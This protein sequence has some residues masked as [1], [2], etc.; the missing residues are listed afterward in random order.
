MKPKRI[1]SIFLV[2]CMIAPMLFTVP[3][4]A[5]ADW[6]YRVKVVVSDKKDAGC[7][8]KNAIKVTLTFDGSDET[9]YLQGKPSRGDTTQAVIKSSRAP[10]TLDRVELENTTKD[11]LWMYRIYIE[12]QRDGVRAYA[13]LLDNYPGNKDD[14]K[15]GMPIDVDDGGP[16]RYAVKFN[17]S[18]TIQYPDDFYTQLSGEEY[19]SSSGE[20]GTVSREWSGKLADD[21]CYV[22]D[23]N[24]MYNCMEMSDPPEFKISASGIKGDGS[25][26]SDKDL[27]QNGYTPTERGFKADKAALVSYMNKNNINAVTI[28]TT[29]TFSDKSTKTNKY[30]NSEAKY[31]F[32][33]DTFSISS[34]NL[35]SNYFTAGIDNYFYNNSGNRKITATCTIKTEGNCRMFNSWVLAN[36][37]IKFDNAYLKAGDNIKITAI[38][39]QTGKA[40]KGAKLSGAAF[41]LEFPYA[42]NLD[43]E[44]AGTALV[45]ENAKLNYSFLNFV[46]HDYKLWDEVHHRHGFANQDN[47]EGYLVST[48]KIDSKNPTVVL[49]AASGTDLNKWNKTV[50]LTSTPS[51]DI[52][53]YLTRGNMRTQGYYTMY[54][55]DGINT[56]NIY[57][58]NYTEKD[59]GTAATIQKAPA[60]KNFTQNVTLALRDK[61]EGV[62][63]LVLTGQDF[64]GNPLSV[65]HEGIK[66]DNK[67]PVV[68]I[69]EKQ[70][71]KADGKKG[72]IYNV[73][74]SDASGTGRLYYMFTKKSPADAPQYDGSNNPATSGSMDTTLDRWAFI[75]QKDTENGK[76]AAAYLDVEKG[77]SFVG[78]IMYFAVDEA[79]N[80]TE[81][82]SKEININNED[83]A[84]SI[85]P[86]NPDYPRSGY[87]ITIDTNSNNTVEYRWKYYVKENADSDRMT[88]KF[89]TDYYNKYTGEI[90][91][92][93]DDKTKNL[94]GTYI[95][96][97]KVTPPSGTNIKYY[98]REYMFDN[99]G[100]TINITTP[101]AEAKSNQTITV[102]ATDASDV[103]SA[104]AKLTAPNGSDIAGN[105][106]FPVNVTDGILSQNININNAASGAYALKVT[107]TDRNGLSNTE[108][109]KPFFIRNTAP[110]GTV[111]VSSSL[112]YNGRSLISNK[113]YKLDFDITDSFMNAASIGGQSLYYRVSAAAGEYGEWIKAGAM[114]SGGNE[115]K[116]KLTADALPIEFVD[117]ENI[118]FVQTAVSS[119]SADK[120]KIDLNTV[121]TDE[122]VF[123]YDNTPPSS[124]LVIDDAHTSES[125]KGKLYVADNLDND[126]KASCNSSAVTIGDFTNSAFDVTV[127]ENTDTSITVKDTAGN[128]TSVKLVIKGIDTTPPTAE[129]SV[130]DKYTGVRKDAAATVKINDVYGGTV[131]IGE[132]EQPG[133]RFAFIPADKYDGSGKIPE[134]FFRDNLDNY[135]VYKV[136]ES[137]SEQAQWDGESNM[138][139]N[140]DI[141][142]I[143]GEWFVGVR[144]ADSLG[145]MTDIIFD[146]TISAQDAELSAELSVK[147][148]KTEARTIGRVKYNVPVY[149]LPQ[150]KIVDINSDAVKNNTLNLELNGLSDKEK[151]E[152][153]NLELA[154][155]Y[156]M[157]Y[158]DSYSFAASANGDYELYTVDDI[159]RTKHMT[160][161][162]S[163]VEFGAASGI[164]ATVYKKEWSDASQ[165]LVYNPVGENEMV[166]AVSREYETAVVIEPT[167]ASDTL[168][169]PIEELDGEHT[170]GLSFDANR[171]EAVYKDNA[172]VPSVAPDGTG[173]S[174]YG[175]KKIQGYK[176]LVYGVSQI[177][178]EDKY[179]PANVT[180]RAV[181]VKA[182]NKDADTSNPDEVSEKTIVI[183]GI[184]NTAPAV[185]WSSN[186]EVYTYED[187]TQDGYTYKDWVTHPTPGN[188]EFTLT[189]QDKESGITEI[190]VLTYMDEN[191]N[192]EVVKVPLADET[193]KEDGYWSWD[194]SGHR[195][196]IDYD[197]DEETGS[198]VPIY[199]TIPVKAEYYGDS[200]MYGVKT[201]KL[202]FT[203]AYRLDRAGAFV[204]SLGGEGYAFI[205][206]N[207]SGISTYDVIYKMPIT[208]GE[209]YN[210]KYYY[211]NSEGNWE[212]ITDI[213]NTYYKN[214][215]A[216]IEKAGRADERG[217]YVT[218][219]SGADGE[220]LAEKPLNNYQNSFTF[221]LKDK[222]G[223]TKSV[224]VLLENFD[225]EPGELSYALSTTSKTNKPV[226]VTIEVSDAKSGVGTVK[227]TG[228]GGE[229]ALTKLEDGKYKGE[230]SKNG[231][232]SAAL[233]DKAGNKT[234]KSFNISNI[235]TALP[236]A[237]V[238]YSTKELTSRPVTATLSFSK[239]NVRITT[240]EPVAPLTEADYSVNYTTSVITFT[241][242]GT[243]GV[244]FEDDYGNSNAD[245]PL[246]V[247]VGNIDKT[248]PRLEPVIDNTTEPSVAAVTF[249]KVEDLA[250]ELSKQRKESE[251][252]VTYGGI[253][254]AVAD[255]KGS[256]NSFVFYQNGNYTFKVHDKE[257]MSSYLSITI[258]GIDLKAPVIKSVSWSYDYDEYDG[259][260]WIARNF[261]ETITPKEGSAG[262]VVASD[263]YN[264]TNKDVTVTVTTDD[265]T[266]LVGSSDDY[267]KVKEKNYDQNGLFIFNP[268]KRNN[269]TASY[270]VDIEVIDKAAPTIDLLG[271]SEMVFY[272][273]PEM[274]TDYDRSMLEYVNGGKYKAY[275]AYDIF[276]GVKTDLTESVKVVDWGGFNPNNLNSNK[277]DS[278]S[279]YTITYQ[280]SDKAHNITEAKRTIRLIGMYDTVALVNGKL[281]DFAGR[282]E[283]YGDS[284]KISLKNFAGTAYAR[285]QKGV[286]T[287]GQ[288]KKD[289]TLVSRNSDGDFE[290]T[291]LSEGWYTFYVQT[292]KRD[293]FTLCVYLCN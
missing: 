256:K 158:S 229:T 110:T 284:V 34:V 25:A 15:S 95:L 64:A 138:V 169:L 84:C 239:P 90:D 224:P 73:K 39:P 93:K 234:V 17:P 260:D 264:V 7:G 82:N 11:S 102:Y 125:I 47:F 220:A 120:N 145:N 251:I 217:L 180:E 85:T 68:E 214:A 87:N 151:V 274:N 272:E 106:E 206:R 119:D 109:S 28:T 202:T 99:E 63:K 52:Y 129:M 58:F 253:T 66:L 81:V 184:D 282:S 72:N 62:Y 53:S 175:E 49:S 230:I 43:S 191:G 130:T 247:A 115:L 137:R 163:G 276:G 233:Y 273:N 160:V 108:L 26:A 249:N 20:S 228:G 9:G 257:G 3:V 97:C 152:A 117:G 176:K 221:K 37:T 77:Q 243:V 293:Y 78:R 126:L 154:K 187:V 212:E 41:S 134:G 103:V 177:M 89:I 57:K 131:K 150:D 92:L 116:A 265:D 159:G 133:I 51:E 281:P 183:G 54:L 29:L 242:S 201:L 144:A 167:D 156:A 23:S 267:G 148:M 128:E 40:A 278:G 194:G 268:E 31:T 178:E 44:N 240:I 259:T 94:N 164:K 207:E 139:Y 250:S 288:M 162:V 199:G 1:L 83:T 269:L 266:R 55:T 173:G 157:S 56:P 5:A 261:S 98:T 61:V 198:S 136:S 59:T 186:P 285:Y 286:K 291:G 80:K 18:R 19:L 174:D 124:T 232:Y 123:Y 188:V 244:C 262:Y 118:L 210:L 127:S 36:S 245:N 197:Y 223:Y 182:F 27:Q 113:E 149:T 122:I 105:D 153:V 35:S 100:P 8:K 235:N 65:V 238:S 48:H 75:E 219:C 166:C 280:V 107:V 227:L 24:G 168:L 38:D 208:E 209:D 171:S 104:T 142:G 237:E 231:T 46:N 179:I 91:T 21:Y 12:A 241:K 111:D 32:Y 254:K 271:T 255:E 216:V 121:K 112:K 196:L 4:S 22:A 33:R 185:T 289:G 195:C 60:L 140:V 14:K 287:M 6:E 200:D 86:T 279:P 155:H 236:E 172:P 76:T 290:V 252:F 181:T 132:N 16:K 263:K 270:G 283:A 192:E 13:T 218:N 79:G 71:P 193:V 204:N 189:A 2:I 248:P 88:E 170:N 190:I 141:S 203:D 205:A 161:T 211:Q 45:L 50:T 114:T 70:Q 42:E 275:E 135:S 246:I 292:D 225:I 69:S 96:D 101:E 277:F 213:E 258:D 74:I 10:W 146:K 147:P 215:K 222:Y 226:E 67:A 143:S 30:S 165:D